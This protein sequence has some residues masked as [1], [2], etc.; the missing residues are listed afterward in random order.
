LYARF[1]STKIEAKRRR[2]DSASLFANSRRDKPKFAGESI[3]PH[4][5][6]GFIDYISG[7]IIPGVPRDYVKFEVCETGKVEE[8]TTTSPFGFMQRVYVSRDCP[9]EEGWGFA[10]KRMSLPNNYNKSPYYFIRIPVSQFEK[11]GK[12]KVTGLWSSE[13]FGSFKAEEYFNDSKNAYQTK[14]WTVSVTEGNTMD[15]YVY[16]KYVPESFP[17]LKR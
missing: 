4:D 12:Y 13:V 16:C 8:R 10:T 14:G 5:T 7:P 6:N 17:R 15:G 9:F 3:E 11:I 1:K 2:E